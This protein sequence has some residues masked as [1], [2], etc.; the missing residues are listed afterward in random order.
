MPPY[1]PISA[2]LYAMVQSARPHQ[3]VKN[4]FV[5]VPLIFSREVGDADRWVPTLAG[6]GAFCLVS[7]SIYVFNDLSDRE[8]DRAHPVKRHRPI[9]SG[10]LPASMAIGFATVLATVGLGVGVALQPTFGWVLAGYALLNVF[11][12]HVGKTIPYVD[13][14][15]IASGFLLRVLGGASVARVPPSGYLLVVTFFLSCFLAFGKRA[16]EL[17]QYDGGRSTRPV[18]RGYRGRTVNGF[19]YVSGLLTLATY[20]IYTLDPRTRAFFS[21]DQLVWTTPL[22]LVGIL[23]FVFLV[24]HPDQAESPT[25]RMLRDGPFLLNLAAWFALTTGLIYHRMPW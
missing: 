18:L 11:Y 23:R 20:V 10:R 1:A 8:L 25:E 9:A 13:V 12:T 21:T 19:L 15:C 4:L 22:P 24:H 17:A 5:W 6:F 3:W 2:R 7:S 16:H 14:L